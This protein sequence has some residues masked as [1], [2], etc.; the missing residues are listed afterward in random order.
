LLC[1]GVAYIFL[2]FQCCIRSITILGFII[3]AGLA[4]TFWSYAG[5]CHSAGAGR[6][7]Y[8]C[9]TGRK[10]SA[11]SFIRGRKECNHLSYAM[12][13]AVDIIA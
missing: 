7:A 10:K 6:S 12:F 9:A 1:D 5:I 13:F 4:A 11:V 2:S 3:R 8:R